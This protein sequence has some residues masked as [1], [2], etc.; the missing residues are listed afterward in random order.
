[1]KLNEKNLVKLAVTGTVSHP[2]RFEA[3]EVDAQGEAHMVPSVG[4]IVYNVKVGDNACGWRGDHIEPG[5]SITYHPEKKSSRQNMA[6]QFLTCIGNEVLITSG[7]A[8]G[9]KG[10]VT[11]QHGGVEHVMVDFDQKT[12]DKLNGDERFLI[13]ALGQGLQ[14]E[15]CSDV[16][17]FN[18]A[19]SLLKKMKV[20]VQKGTL[21]VPVTHKVPAAIMGSGIGHADPG[22]GDYDITT[23]D[24]RMVKRY[25][26]DKLRLG[27]FVAIIDADN[28]YGRHYYRGAVTIAIVSHSDSFLSGHGPGVTTL[29]T[30]KTGKIKPIIDT[31]ANIGKILRVGKFRS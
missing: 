20:K 27:D 11:G 30:S 3:F 24:E 7:P 17:C 4:G 19:P 5:V 15:A 28:T 23:Q 12:L 21:E 1:M 13:R 22:T 29:L 2:I 9:A 26:L 8:K 16:T 10:V 6:M 14:I 25:G 18:L 31:N